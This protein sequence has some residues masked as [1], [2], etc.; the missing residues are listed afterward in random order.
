V[1]LVCGA[2]RGSDT[3]CDDRAV[4]SGV[5]KTLSGSGGQPA[6]GD[7]LLLNSLTAE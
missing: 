4:W 2:Y 6:I 5:E 1:E 7:L 3:R